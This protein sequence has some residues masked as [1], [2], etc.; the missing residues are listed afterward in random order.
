MAKE[1][2]LVR[3][4]EKS[5]EEKLNQLESKIN[6]LKEEKIRTEERLK[7]LRE[8]KNEVIKELAVFGVTPKNLS[9]VID[10]LETEI[11]TELADIDSQIPENIE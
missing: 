11:S 5:S 9:K 4:E 7:N 8:Q 2:Q 6:S 10:E 3:E 1:K